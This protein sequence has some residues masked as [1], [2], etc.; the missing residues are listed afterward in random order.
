MITAYARNGA[1]ALTLLATLSACA[2]QDADS[3]PTS[4]ASV[5]VQTAR[6]AITARQQAKTPAPVRTPQ[7]QATE[8]LRVNAGPLIQVGF[9]SLGRN[10]VLALTGQNGTMRTY[11][12]PAEEAV[13]LRNG[14]LVGTKGFG[15]DL[16][17]AEP[18]TE[19]LIRAGQ[20]GRGTRIMRYLGGDGLERPLQFDCTTGPGPNA[21]V[22]VEDCTGHGLSF[23]NSY[24]VSGGQIPVSRQWVGPALGYITVQ[25]LRP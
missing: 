14:M 19:G 6:D 4:A 1:M 21:G 18:G 9:E 11:M 17:V 12:T 16:A 15:N 13:I 20:S 5:L 10:Q 22:M 7:E 25:T 23:Q 2:N 3:T 8:A 24:A